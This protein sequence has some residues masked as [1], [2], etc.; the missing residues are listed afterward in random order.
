MTK[1]EFHKLWTLIYHNT[2]PISHLF[3]YDYSDKWFRIH[4]LPESKRY[5]DNNNEWKIL[6]SRQN[7]IIT[8]L[9]GVGANILIVKSDFYLS[10]DVKNVFKDYS[11]N[12]LDNI[13]LYELDPNEF[14]NKQTYHPSFAE[15][16]WNPNQHDE[17]LRAIANDITR[18]FFISFNKK[19]IAAPYDGGIDFIPKN[20]L[21]RDFYR[22]KYK[23]WISRHESAF[24]YETSLCK[25]LK[26]NK[27]FGFNSL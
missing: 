5:A 24:K 6:L 4:S 9:F 15:T 19:I 12:I 3:K 27:Y 13:N 1:E 21:T 10:N 20:S 18:T 25:K 8:D 26:P 7:E 11:F 14:N 22:N 16:I 23:Q 17:L 2:I